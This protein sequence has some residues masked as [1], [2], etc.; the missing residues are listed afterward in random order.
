MLNF[1]TQKTMRVAQQLYEGVD[2][3]GEGTVGLITYLRTDS[4][5]ISDEANA[6]A[7]KFIESEYGAEYLGQAVKA[8]DGSAGEGDAGNG[9]GSATDP[10]CP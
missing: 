3:K 10:G 4:T 1:G 2:I 5:R 8:A 6:S 9:S 7:A